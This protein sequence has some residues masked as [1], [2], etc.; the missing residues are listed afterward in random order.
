MTFFFFKTSFSNLN[1]FFHYLSFICNLKKWRASQLLSF[2]LHYNRRKFH[3]QPFICIKTLCHD[4]VF[5]GESQ[6]CLQHHGGRIRV[7]RHRADPALPS[8]IRSDHTN[9]SPRVIVWGV[10]HTYLG[11]PLPALK[12]LW[13]V[14]ITFTLL[15]KFRNVPG[16]FWA[17]NMPNLYQ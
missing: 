7:L 8:C 15:E 1:W 10:L 4:I 13:K 11:H 12:T 2:T 9:P 6:F 17:T 5:S 16:N 3:Y 14:A